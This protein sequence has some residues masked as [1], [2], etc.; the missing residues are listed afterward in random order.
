MLVLDLLYMK[1]SEACTCISEPKALELLHA[2]TLLQLT[3]LPED[4]EHLHYAC[5]HIKAVDPLQIRLH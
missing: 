2:G 3:V 5:D 4:P 1:R